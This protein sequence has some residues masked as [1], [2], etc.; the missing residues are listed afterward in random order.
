MAALSIRSQSHFIE[1]PGGYRLHVKEWSPNDPTQAI[2]I[3]LVHGAI[4]NGKIFHSNSGRGLAPFLAR[5]GYRTFTLDRRGRGQSTPKLS[6]GS[7]FG[8]RDDLLI[9]LPLFADWV[10]EKTGA[11]DAA[12]VAHSWGGVLLASMLARRPEYQGRARALVFFGTKRQVL[13][14][15]WEI[16]WKIRFFWLNAARW[17]AKWYGFLPAESLGVGSD[18]ETVRTLEDSCAW[19]RPSKW[20]DPQDGFDYEP[21]LKAWKKP[22]SLWFAGAGDRALANPDDVRVTLLEAGFPADAFRL[23]GARNGNKRDY[24]HIDMLTHADA[25]A[26]HFQEVA[27]FFSLSLT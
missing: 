21:A 12:W 10:R 17:I 23:L 27:L 19:V 22:P 24:G 20:V 1:A 3:L 6:S 4:E 14:R 13:A 9:D 15:N 8:Q 2:P 5:Q 7:D 25:E 26:D 18:R 11:Q 16:F